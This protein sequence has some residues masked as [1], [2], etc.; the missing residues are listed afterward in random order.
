MLDHIRGKTTGTTGDAMRARTTITALA[1]AGYTPSANGDVLV[2]STDDA[3]YCLGGV[4]GDTVLFLDSTT[5]TVS[6][7]PCA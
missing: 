7:H 4:T 1:T 2:E 6:D 5:G 3:G